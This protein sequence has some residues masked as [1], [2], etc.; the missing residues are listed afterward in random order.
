MLLVECS[1]FKE[2]NTLEEEFNREGNFFAVPIKKASMVLDLIDGLG[3]EYFSED[4]EKEKKKNQ[5]ATR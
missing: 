4:I 3:Y 1:N 5:A 2:Q